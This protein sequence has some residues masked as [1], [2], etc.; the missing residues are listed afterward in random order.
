ERVRVERLAMPEQ[1]DDDREAHGRFRRGHG[2]DEEHDDLPLDRAE[3]PAD[4]HERQVDGVEHDLDR[5]EDRDQVAPEEDAG[6]AGG[7]EDGREHEEVVERGHH[8]FRFAS[9]TAPT[10]ATT[11]S[12]DVTSN[13]K[14]YVVNSSTPMFR[15][16]DTI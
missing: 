5:Q 7:E 4:G 12:S 2:H 10:M 1:R 13:A 6:R 16:D 15:T 3:V 14:E 8:R 9:V 11:I